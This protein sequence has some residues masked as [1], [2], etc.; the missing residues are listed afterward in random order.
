[1]LSC[2]HRPPLK[3][4]FQP[5]FCSR[6]AERARC[7][8]RCHL[9]VCR[10][11]LHL[12][13]VDPNASFLCFHVREPQSGTDQSLVT[14]PIVWFTPNSV[15]K[16]AFPIRT[17]IN[18]GQT[19]FHAEVHRC[20]NGGAAFDAPPGHLT[21]IPNWSVRAQSPPGPDS[22]LYRTRR[23]LPASIS[24]TAV[25]EPRPWGSVF[26]LCSPVNSWRSRLPLHFHRSALLHR[27]LSSTSRSGLSTL[28]IS[29][30][31]ARLPQEFKE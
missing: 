19:F 10:C 1:V 2:N 31:A 24:P 12:Q 16:Y 13:Y 14:L 22:A 15:V 11:S 27:R 23:C 5:S 25:C 26:V 17:V 8:I 21:V 18:P 28:S 20:E 3:F 7:G 9:I 6:P 4:P 29:S 30:R